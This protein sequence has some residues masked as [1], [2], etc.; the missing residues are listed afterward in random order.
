MARALLLQQL[1]LEL[2]AALLHPM[3][4]VVLQPGCFLQVAIAL[5]F[6]DLQP[7]AFV[8]GQELPQLGE[9][10]PLPLPALL[11]LLQPC[12]GEATLLLQGHPLSLRRALR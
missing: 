1:R 6:S 11:Q 5:G 4:L 3:Q 8:V 9:F 7:Q 12:V 10:L 2:T